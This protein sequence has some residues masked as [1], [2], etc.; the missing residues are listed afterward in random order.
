MSA[1]LWKAVCYF[2]QHDSESFYNFIFNGNFVF[3]RLETKWKLLRSKK[4]RGRK[5]FLLTLP[6][7]MV[8]NANPKNAL[9]QYFK[10]CLTIYQ[11]LLL[12]PS[13]LFFFIYFQFAH[14]CMKYV[15]YVRV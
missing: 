13:C 9:T 15:K 14:C 4:K 5:T 3:N 11:Q 1:S 7:N 12:F 10:D 2:P 8:T 6:C